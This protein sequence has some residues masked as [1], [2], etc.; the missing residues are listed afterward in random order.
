MD[1]SENRIHRFENLHKLTLLE[2]LNL[3]GNLIKDLPKAAVEPL[4]CLK[5]LKLS[6]NKISSL[7]EIANLAILPNL[8]NLFVAGNQVCEIEEYQ[9]FVIYYMSSLET[10]DGVLITSQFRQK[11]SKKHAGPSPEAWVVRENLVS[12]RRNLGEKNIEKKELVEELEEVQTEIDK[13]RGEIEITD[14]SIEK[15]KT[16]ID[17]IENALANTGES[18]DDKKKYMRDL[19][20]KT[21]NLRDS[22]VNLQERMSY[23]RTVLQET[24]DSFE[25]VSKQLLECKASEKDRLLEEK[26]RLSVVIDESEENIEELEAQYGIVLEELNIATTAISKIEEE[27]LLIRGSSDSSLWRNSKSRGSHKK[28]S[29][30]AMDTD[31]KHYLTS[32]KQEIIQEMPELKL[33]RKQLLRELD[34]LCA[35]LESKQLL[36]RDL[37]REI[38]EL[39]RQIS[40]CEEYLQRINTQSPLRNR[41]NTRLMWESVKGLWQLLTDNPWEYESDDIQKGIIR[42]AEH[43]KEH[44]NRK[45]IDHEQYLQALAQQRVDQATI[46]HITAKSQ[47]LTEQLLAKS[48]LGE[49]ID[50]LHAKIDGLRD[51]EKR[52]GFE[53]NELIEKLRQAEALLDLSE[54]RVKE[55]GGEAGRLECG[56]LENLRQEKEEIEESIKI[57]NDQAES[58]EAELRS[59]MNKLQGYCENKAKE[60]H[61]LTEEYEEKAKGLTEITGEVMW[62]QRTKEEMM[63]A[64]E[65]LSASKKDLEKENAKFREEI[66]N[67]KPLK[68]AEEEKGK[69]VNMLKNIAVTIG[70]YSLEDSF[71]Y[72]KFLRIFEERCEKI[73]EDLAKADKFK[74]NKQKFIEMYES[75]TRE[76]QEEWANLKGAKEEF[77]IEKARIGSVRID[78][79]NLDDQMKQLVST[80]KELQRMKNS[81]E[82]ETIKLEEHSNSLKQSINTYDTLKQKEMNEYNRIQILHE[83]EMKKL[84]ESTQELKH[85]KTQIKDKKSEKSELEAFISSAK[86]Q[87]SKLTERRNTLEEDIKNNEGILY[88][89]SNKLTEEQVKVQKEVDR[90]RMHTEEKEREIQNY[91]NLIRKYESQ[92]SRAQ[93]DCTDASEKLEEIARELQIRESSLRDKKNSLKEIEIKCLAGDTSLDRATKE[94]EILSQSFASKKQ[95]ISQLDLEISTKSSEIE[96]L[97]TKHSQSASELLQVEKQI[98]RIK[99]DLQ[100]I[101]LIINNKNSE[102]D[103]LAHQIKKKSSELNILDKT[104]GEKFLALSKAEQQFSDI[105][106]QARSE[107]ETILIFREE[108]KNLQVKISKLTEALKRVENQKRQV[109]QEIEE[110]NVKLAGEEIRHRK[111]IENLRNAV[112]NGESTLRQ[113][114]ESVQRCR[115]KL[116]SDKE[117]SSRLVE[118]IDRL[119][120]QREELEAVN[121]ELH[122]EQA[123]VNEE[124]RKIRLEEDTAMVLLALSGHRID[125]KIK[126]RITALCRAAG[127]LEVLRAQV[128]ESGYGEESREAVSADRP[129]LPSR[130]ES[131]ENTSVYE[132]AMRNPRESQV[133]KSDN[134]EN[135]PQM[136]PPE[137]DDMKKLLHTL[138]VTQQRLRS[139]TPINELSFER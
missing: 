132:G 23:E 42:W 46:D 51:K 41:A 73:K 4:K 127:E 47:E 101:E 26:R 31:T 59:R 57:M 28:E 13:T 27:I 116:S 125:E 40:E 118:D 96:R 95:K 81:L 107:E 80:T 58:Q 5:S 108:S 30:F 49:E 32:R 102:Y 113:L 76:L 17:N 39:T 1:L 136:V 11:A 83:S 25:T 82:K 24:R 112:S 121:R 77:E 48:R 92:L 98:T 18:A 84:E 14:R 133:E 111:E 87:V 137:M 9:L 130:G 68:D 117:E 64:V 7:Q 74:L 35:K 85:L 104:L 62:L 86:S 114:M 72:S 20:D 129:R 16:E 66:Q 89:I 65:V 50:E 70:I 105:H 139:L 124:V 19:L 6:K 134:Y 67:I 123:R 120:Q 88:K 34:S 135:N 54:R 138:E 106:T 2:T 21:E 78:K 93:S 56:S 100:G 61:C 69:I 126:Q 97:D 55:Y 37:E 75:N 52:W 43:M 109:L 103:D 36:C 94:S 22:S 71:D 45:K 60:L 119:L 90:V 131:Y 63:K 12:F 128:S 79:K 99:S 91:E 15:N 38:L 110:I 29:S 115:N 44:I 3:S 33:R 122:A 10:L 8:E 53:K